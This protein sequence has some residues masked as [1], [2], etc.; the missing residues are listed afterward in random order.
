MSDL[1]ARLRKGFLDPILGVNR[2]T[3]I[4]IEAA[5]ALEA[6]DNYI[7]KLRNAL[8]CISLGS[9]N[10]MTTMGDLG[11]EARIA[12]N[13]IPIP[14]MAPVEAQKITALDCPHCAAVKE[15]GGFCAPSEAGSRARVIRRLPK[16]KLDAGFPTTADFFSEVWPV[17][18]AALK[19][20]PNP[21]PNNHKMDTD[22]QVFFYEQDFYVLSNFSAFTVVLGGHIYQTAEHAYHTFKF[23]DDPLKQTSIRHAAS[24]HD[25]FKLAERWAK[26]R[27]PEWETVRLNVMKRIL[28]AKVEQHAYVR[29][30]LLATGD[31]ELIE[32]SW[33]DDFWG[34][35]PNR[36]GQNMLGRL[37]MQLRTE[38]QEAK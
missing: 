24:A 32:D 25:A 5:E 7:Y 10:S 30:K 33:R 29:R 37:W 23:P 14:P 6:K 28:R 12:L 27:T 35:G 22:E 9:Q 1:I 16:A 36:D 15:A 38:L 8:H 3:P 19:A 26:Y 20:R 13:Q 21:N 2:S 17:A 11:R 4:E 34:W 31:R 18:L